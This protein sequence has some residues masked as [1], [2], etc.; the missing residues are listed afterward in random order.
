MKLRFLALLALVALAFSFA[1]CKK[2]ENP[3]APPTTVITLPFNI[4]SEQLTKL[5][6]TLEELGKAYEDYKD[7]KVLWVFA[8]NSVFFV[9]KDTKHVAIL[10]LEGEGEQRHVKEIELINNMESACTGSNLEQLRDGMTADAVIRT[11]GI[12]DSVTS[13]GYFIYRINDTVFYRLV[14]DEYNHLSDGQHCTD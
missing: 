14:W 10:D 5:D 4:T 8:D 3:E 13:K 12:P 6:M 1:S 2:D 9:A 7:G 11:V